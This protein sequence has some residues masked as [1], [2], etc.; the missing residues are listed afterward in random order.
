[1]TRKTAAPVETPQNPIPE[2]EDDTPLSF[3]SPE[4]STI[5]GAS[6]DPQ[7]QQMRIVFL[8]AAYGLMVGHQVP[9]E[10]AYDYPGFPPNEWRDFTQAASKGAYFSRHIRPRYTGKPV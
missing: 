7:A 1:M 6:Y 4:S 9:K 8:G 2:E 3:E 10:K 5:K